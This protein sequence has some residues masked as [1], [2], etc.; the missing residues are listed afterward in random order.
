MC[1]FTFNIYLLDVRLSPA[2]RARHGRAA[3]ARSPCALG[4]GRRHEPL[5]T[6]RVVPVAAR[7]RRGRVVEVLQAYRALERRRCAR[8]LRSRRDCRLRQLELH[9]DGVPFA[10]RPYRAPGG[11]VRVLVTEVTPLAACTRTATGLFGCGYRRRLLRRLPRGPWQ[12][13]FNCARSRVKARRRR[14]FDAGSRLRRRT[15]RGLGNSS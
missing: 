2:E 13:F 5:H 10:R 9:V 14:R 11:R 12:F 3:A 15:N 6:G 7:E 4:P 8:P 1:K